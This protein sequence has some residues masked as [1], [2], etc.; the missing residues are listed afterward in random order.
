MCKGIIKSTVAV[1]VL[2]VFMTLIVS[3]ALAQK[4]SVNVAST[5]INFEEGTMTI[6]GELLL[7]TMTKNVRNLRANNS[8]IMR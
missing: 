7:T 5:N 6:V 2:F 4:L 3:G 8:R 1:L